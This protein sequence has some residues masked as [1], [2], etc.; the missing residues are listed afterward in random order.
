MKGK[1]LFDACVE[2]E[3]VSINTF[4]MH[5][6]ECV[7]QSVL[8]TGCFDCF[9]A[10]H[11]SLIRFAYKSQTGTGLIP[12]VIVGVNSDRAVKKLKGINRPI[13]NEDDRCS[14]VGELQ[15]V[16][17]SFIID[18]E[19]VTESIIKLRPKAWVKGAD[20][21]L[22]TLNQEERKAAE[23]VGTKIIFAPKIEGYSSTSIIE[24]MKG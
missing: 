24:R 8:V 15:S 9:H 19:T 1:T 13:H 6:G 18:D 3:V 4:R 22:E 23:L 5:H 21:T 11:L 12:F 14:L 16:S 7:S 10:G 2:K 17:L 20:Y